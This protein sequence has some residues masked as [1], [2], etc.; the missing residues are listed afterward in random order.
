MLIVIPFETLEDVNSV[1]QMSGEIY[2]DFCGDKGD[3]VLT[4]TTLKR[5]HSAQSGKLFGIAVI[6][7]SLI[8]S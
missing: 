6:F 5:L 1:C 3:H 7:Y 2:L 8:L 4:N